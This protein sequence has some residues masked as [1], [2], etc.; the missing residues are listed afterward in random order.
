VARDVPAREA[1]SSWPI[2]PRGRNLTYE[3]Q[4]LFARLYLEGL[5]SG[6]FEPAFRELLGTRAPLSSG[7]ARARTSGS[8]FRPP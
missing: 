3:T 7:V 8:S 1:R 5:S 6:D 2:L 4:R